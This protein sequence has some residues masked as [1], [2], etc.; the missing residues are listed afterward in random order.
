MEL[1]LCRDIY[2]CTPVELAKIPAATILA[3]LI[4]LDVEA[5][6]H[7]RKSRKGKSRR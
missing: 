1:V 7:R 3:H 4:C 5:E 2:H 6:V